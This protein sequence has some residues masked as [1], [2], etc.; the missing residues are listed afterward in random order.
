MIMMR[1]FLLAGVAVLLLSGAAHAD[2]CFQVQKTPDG[3]LALRASPTAK[4]WMYEA[5]R[6]GQILELSPHY[7][8]D[9][10][11]IKN[12]ERWKKVKFWAQN[13]ADPTIGWVY[14]KYIKEVACPSPPPDPLFENLPT[15]P[16]PSH[17][18]QKYPS[19]LGKDK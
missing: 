3:F 10:V 5:L 14:R 12:W 16:V 7:E 11:S 15:I 13:D 6:E 4:A 8:E 1:R 18:V 9:E 19:W 2:K 17:P